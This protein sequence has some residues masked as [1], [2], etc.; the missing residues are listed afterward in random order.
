MSLL[1]LSEEAGPRPDITVVRVAGTF[2]LATLS[3]FEQLLKRLRESGRVKLIV[4]LAGLD[5]IS[6]SG[7]GAFLGVLDPFRAQGG[8]LVFVRVSE[9]VYRILKVVGFTRLLSLAADEAEAMTRFRTPTQEAPHQVI[10]SPALR[11]PHSGEA[12]GLEILAADERGMACVTFAGW[13][14]F[15]ASVGIVSP[16]R[17]GPFKAGVWNGNIVLTGPG[18]TQ[19]RASLE[20]S[21]GTL[22]VRGSA[23]LDLRQ[24]KPPAVLPLKVACP[25]CRLSLN[26][27]A[28]NVYRCKGCDEIY[29]VDKWAHAISLRPGRQ[30]GEDFT[31]RFNLAFPADVNLLG[32]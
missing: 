23:A 4:D 5:Y 11:E 9:R 15:D 19:L 28:F 24:D 18:P 13:A 6:S 1:R 2:D 14:H 10:L 21:S 16:A 8:D 27:H 12:F 17:I 30:G 25:G 7:L 29:F 3:D 31:R 22:D 20:D 26:I 32:A